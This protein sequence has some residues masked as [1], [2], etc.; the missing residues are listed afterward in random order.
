MLK[1]YWFVFGTLTL[2]SQ[3]IHAQSFKFGATAGINFPTI[4]AYNNP[5]NSIDQ[6]KSYSNI[7]IGIVT[8]K[9][10]SKVVLQSGLIL[11]GKGGKD[12]YIN[13]ETSTNR[14]KNTRLF[15]LQVPVDVL[16]KVQTKIGDVYFGGGIYAT[17]GLWGNYSLSGIIFDSDVD[18]SSKVQFGNNENSDYKRTDYGI[19][20]KAEIRFLH[21]IGFELSY[22]Y[23]LRNIAS[24]G[25]YD[26]ANL[27]TRNKVIGFGITYLFKHK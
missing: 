11:D 14:Q 20:F 19:N 9:E 5:T 17:Y 2:L 3:L 15:Y 23:G 13:S 27:K 22:E 4:S 16:Y 6:S 26:D 25:I 7:K 10:W 8:E 1:K 24:P 12:I 18:G 21:G